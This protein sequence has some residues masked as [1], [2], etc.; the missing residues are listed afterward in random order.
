MNQKRYVGG[1]AAGSTRCPHCQSDNLDL[2]READFENGHCYAV[3]ECN[4]CEE[5]WIEVYMLARVVGIS[6]R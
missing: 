4:D 1:V 5:Q 6:D 2:D 3:V